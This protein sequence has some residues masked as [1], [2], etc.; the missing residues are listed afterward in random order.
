MK[1]I[2]NGNE[3]EVKAGATLRDAVSGETYKEGSLIS[4]HMFTE[5]IVSE[6]DDFELMTSAGPMILHLGD[7]DGA[8]FFKEAVKRIEGSTT[9]WVTKEIAAFGAFK[10]EI[11]S[12]KK[13]RRYRKYDC[14]FSLGGFDNHTTYMMIAK[15]EHK[16]SYGAVAENIGRITVGRH[17]LDA[18][19]EGE[20]LQSIKPVI[21]EASSENFVV[22]KDLGMKL[23]DGYKIDT[24]VMIR[25]N[26]NSPASSEHIL[27]TGSKG[28]ITVAD[29]TGSF[30]GCKDDTDVTIPE[31]FHGI[32]DECSVVVRNTGVG[33]G[34]IIF[35]KER[36][37]SSSAHNVA[38]TIER[39]SGLISKA[40]VGEKITIVTEPARVISVGM[41][42]KEGESFLASKGIKQKRDG[43]VSDDAIIVDQD[44]EMTLAAMDKKEVRTI[45]APRDRV[46]R[47]SLSETAPADVYYFRKMTGLSHK[48]VGSL[49]TQ[50]AFPGMPM[51]TFYGDEERSKS[52][53]P[54]DSFK[55]CKK[56]DIGITNQSRPH[57]GLMGIRLEDSKDYG[58][59]GEE[60]YGTNIIGRFLD[61]LSK[62][63]EIEEEEVIYVTEA[64]L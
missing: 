54:Q 21:S 33:T 37:M 57:H 27:T 58:P 23:E 52:L 5:K 34:H 29:A 24:N 13:D 28:Y 11:P 51:I 35:Y 48:P 59:T 60:P 56:G 47:V 64:E 50:F 6:T 40:S 25:L 15:K 36:R 38:G 7:T 16:R 39:G 43:N 4:V 2:V 49:K 8:K 44:P 17:V 53:Y 32:R 46:F 3:K 55:K 42:Q 20:S 31:E 45:G 61:D 62:L 12:D 14:F 30:V 63:S 10:T 19:R 18:L 9:R 22:T 26:V 41:T 1:V